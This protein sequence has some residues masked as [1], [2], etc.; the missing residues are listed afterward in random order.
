VEIRDLETRTK[1]TKELRYKSKFIGRGLIRPVTVRD[2]F[3]RET[4]LI[5]GDRLEPTLALR[6]VSKFESLQPPFRVRFWRCF[7]ED[8]V[9]HD[10]PLFLVPGLNIQTQGPDSLHGWALGPVSSYIPLVLWFL[11]GSSLYTPAI[12]YL[13][14]EDCAKIALMRIKNKLWAHYKVKR[15][16]PRWRAK[17]SEIWNLTLA[18]IGKVKKPTLSIKAA[19]ARGLLEFVVVLLREDT[20]KLP[21]GEKMRG[22]LLLACGE[23]ALKVD[24]A[25][26]NSGDIRN[27]PEQRQQLLNDY[28]HH[29]TLYHRAGG[30]LKPKHH[31]MFH[32]IFG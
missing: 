7:E 21:P 18:M 23:S 5:V 6:D 15:G 24:V 31:M 2:Q 27:T 16:D 1:L 29:V 22:A 26:R 12:D 11:I 14:T 3:G 25:L 20:P 30:I 13:S 17:G 4:N 28:S 19:E 9:I 8:R 32:C 10:S